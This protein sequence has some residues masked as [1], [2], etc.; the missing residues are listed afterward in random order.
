M[1][2]FLPFAALAAFT[3]SGFGQSADR[4]QQMVQQVQ[5]AGAQPEPP[6]AV[7]ARGLIDGYNFVDAGKASMRKQ[8]LAPGTTVTFTPANGGIVYTD[9][10]AQAQTINA[11][12][13]TA[14]IGV[15]YH[16]VLTTSGTTSY[17]ITFGTNFTGAGT[18]ETGTTT[19][20]VYDV[21][22]DF[23]GTAFREVSRQRQSAFAVTVPYVVT[24]STLPYAEG[25]KVY[26]FTPTTTENMAV[27]AAGR[28]GASF[29]LHIIGDASAARTITFTTNVKPS[30]TLATGSS[31]A[32]DSYATFTSDGTNWR[33]VAMQTAG[34]P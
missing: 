24:T 33:V 25:V 20:I 5:P 14:V 10:P 23:D 11:T 27:S 15:P 26:N 8:V 9:T 16:I 34:T 18:L 31:G 22:F 19:A 28:V 12:I 7:L 30:G 17:T 29:V 1:K 2:F 6:I 13:S 32:T 21:C 4:L 3:L